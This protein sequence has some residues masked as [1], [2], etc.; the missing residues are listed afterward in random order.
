MMTEHGKRAMVP[1]DL[2]RIR[3]LSEPQFSPDGARVA[4]VVTTL[5]EEKDAYLSNIWLVD[6]DGGE[7]RRFTTGATRDTDPRWSPDGRALAFLSDREPKKGAQLYL[8]PAG[9]GEA[10]R[11]TD[12]KRGVSNPVWSPDGSRLAFLSRTGGWEEP[13]DE[14]E[15]RKSKPARVISTMRYKSNGEGFIYDRRPH[16]FVVPAAGGA[17]RQVTDGDYVDSDPTWSPDGRTLAFTSARHPDRDYDN[18]SD[19]FLVAGEGGEPRRV[20]DTAGP[21]G[22]PAFSPD[23]RTIAYVGSRHRNEAGRNSRLF[24]VP[25]DGGEAMCL[26]PGLDRSVT[27]FGIPLW[28]GDGRAL[29]FGVSDRGN[30]AVY[31]VT[32]GD[33]GAPGAV[34]PV[35]G[36]ERQI[37][38]LSGCPQAPLFAFLAG[39]PTHPAEIFR[40]NA[41]GSEERQLTDCNRA[42]REEVALAQPERLPYRRDEV[43][44]DC[45]V[46]K[47]PVPVAGGRYPTLLAIH[48]G[49]HSQYGNAFFD[50]FQV[51]AGAGYVVVFTNPRGSQ[52]YGEDFTRAV[53][54]DWGGV[55]FADVMAGLDEAMRRCDAIDP[56]RLGVLG[57]SYGGYLTSWTVGHTE[58]FKAACSERALNTF[59]SFFGVSDIGP[60]FAV[61]E[62]GS[63]PWEN[64]QWYLDH[65]PLTYA[66]NITTPLLIMH[67]ENDLRCPIEQAEQLFTTL[68]RLHREV[69]FIRFPDE[70]HE[71]SRS[72]KP[73][74]RLERFRHI[75]EWFG[76]Y[77]AA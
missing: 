69:L 29:V 49:P 7:P 43:D 1:A 12:L 64:R 15:K 61:N 63:L 33:G 39:D 30:E 56:E 23:G 17:A 76:R 37:S 2:L 60:W 6:V 19:I 38:A 51:Y 59:G 75:L 8:M 24:T 36:G 35:I 52:G 31:R 57:G 67:A 22:N 58:R 44:L 47:P 20:T 32:L 3:F 40:C 66:Q 73:R 18:A 13:D 5:S 27:A 45:W 34:Q 11:L 41:D 65:S 25:I 46:I 54:G 77:L 62:S 55:D 9:G 74:H 68:K 14:E 26:T 10:V 42:W 28:S 72:G 21:S 48:G 50:E 70:T 4:F 53:V 71:L 16:I